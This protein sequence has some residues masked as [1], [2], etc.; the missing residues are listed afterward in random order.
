MRS[1]VSVSTGA[2]VPNVPLSRQ[3]RR[4]HGT[5]SLLFNAQDITVPRREPIWLAQPQHDCTSPT[6]S[7]R[8]G[9]LPCRGLLCNSLRCP[10]ASQ[11]LYWPSPALGRVS[12]GY[13]CGGSAWL[14]FPLQLELHQ[15][16]TVAHGKS[17]GRV[18][19]SNLC[20]ACAKVLCGNDGAS[21]KALPLQPWLALH[22]CIPGS[23]QYRGTSPVSFALGWAFAFLA[24][25]HSWDT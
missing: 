18:A 24:G 11:W 15:S 8:Q 25:F 16:W 6:A 17:C 12:P 21:G 10:Q 7:S 9:H 3:V 23:L 5:S 1:G 19:G 14:R 20:R 13:R 4:L 22:V 2:A